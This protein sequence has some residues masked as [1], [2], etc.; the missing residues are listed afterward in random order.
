[1]NQQLAI[2]ISAVP[3]EFIILF[4]QCYLYIIT[5][6]TTPGCAFFP[7]SWMMSSWSRQLYWTKAFFRTATI[8][9]YGR[10]HHQMPLKHRDKLPSFKVA[11]DRAFDASVAGPPGEWLEEKSYSCQCH[12]W[13]WR[14][15][16]VGSSVL[17]S[18]GLLCTE[19]LQMVWLG[20]EA[21]PRRRFYTE[22]I[23]HV[24]LSHPQAEKQGFSFFFCPK[25]FVHL[26]CFCCI[27]R[28]WG[29]LCKPCQP[30]SL[31]P[32]RVRL[33]KARGLKPIVVWGMK[34][35][36]M[37]CKGRIRRPQLIAFWF[38]MFQRAWNSSLCPYSPVHHVH[39][40]LFII[41]P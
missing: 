36:Q 39:F 33:P 5:C 37:I 4:C 8:K 15:R 41:I 11:L 1:M 19:D 2:F 13:P 23:L 9:A 28:F 18:L 6:L 38:V 10:V 40:Q 30:E 32:C 34:D 17:S 20:G 25:I 16:C 27:G 35:L 24:F 14:Q 21:P 12:T 29:C 26:K 3:I 7:Q 22:P 31:Q